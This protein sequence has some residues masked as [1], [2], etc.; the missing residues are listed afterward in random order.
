MVFQRAT[1]LRTF[2]LDRTKYEV[3]HI[4][5]NVRFQFLPKGGGVSNM[6]AQ[7]SRLLILL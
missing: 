2:L 6:R 5:P 4:D 3:F 7:C 1:F